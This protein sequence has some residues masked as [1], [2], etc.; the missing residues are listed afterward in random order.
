MMR[1]EFRMPDI[2]EG[3][4]EGEI[5]EWHVKPGDNVEEEQ[6]MVE[7]TTDKA[8]V[9]ID[10]PTSGV[11]TELCA[12]VGDIVNVGTVIAVIETKASEKP[13]S[14][15]RPSAPATPAATA[16]GDIKDSLLPGMAAFQKSRQKNSPTTQGNG[17]SQPPPPYFADKPMATPATRKLARDLG[18]DL[19]QVKPSGDSARVTKP[20]VM[21]FVNGVEQH[22]AAS[23]YMHS[24]QGAM[25]PA[26]RDSVPAPKK[27]ELLSEPPTQVH[28]MEERRPF[29]G[30]RRRIAERM[31]H[32][33]NTAAH[34]TFVEECDVGRLQDLRESLKEEAQ[35]NDV[36]LAYLPFIVKAVVAALKK[37][38]EL[39]TILDE[40]AN[41][42]VTRKYHHIGIATATER[43]LLVPVVRNADQ[44][45]VMEVAKE[46]ER[47]AKGAREG[48]LST[49]ELHGSTFTVT[50]L[51]KHGGLFATPVLN[52]PEVGIL[53]VHRMR[54][55]AIVKDGQITIG[56]V[57]LL[58]FSFDHRLID[59]H[60]GAAFAYEII[61]YL[62]NPGRLFL[63]M[64]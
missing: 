32:A 40:E 4:S 52:F 48:S 62:E 46:I 5:V 2:G 35:A 39:N 25:T 24:S 58:S 21:N 27:A 1:F 20:D 55:R 41:E 56:N 16:V 31:Q 17:H 59:G 44:L 14:S 26:R 64:R 33:K 54:Q 11:V 38:P 6:A 60:V 28:D 63:E 13:S 18:V 22:M 29:V 19:R 37:H 10:M 43:G 12:K 34:F 15:R 9:T 36:K 61:H 53:A 45:S 30:I 23:N 57:M 8:S 50:S 47:L 51:G 42:L 3:V 49:S 7:V